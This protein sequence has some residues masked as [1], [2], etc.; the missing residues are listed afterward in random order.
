MPSASDSHFAASSPSS[1]AP[2]VHSHTCAGTRERASSL[3]FP[4]LAGT[5]C[6][7]SFTGIF[8]EN[9]PRLAPSLL[10]PASKLHASTVCLFDII[11]CDREPGQSVACSSTSC[12]TSKGTC[13]SS[14][15][16]KDRVK[17]APFSGCQVLLGAR[18]ACARRS[19]GNSVPT[20]RA[21]SGSSGLGCHQAEPVFA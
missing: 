11:A 9:E 7:A 13:K 10:V 12:V 21:T 1:N 5:E 3:C 6:C 4:E 14:L 18:S 17:H 20:C 15:L 16:G 19:S 8:D 2:P